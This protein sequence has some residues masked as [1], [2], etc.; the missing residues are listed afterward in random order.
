MLLGCHAS[1]SSEVQDAG[2]KEVQETREDVA[3]FEAS[4]RCSGIAVKAGD[5]RGAVLVTNLSPYYLVKLTGVVTIKKPDGT[6]SGISGLYVSEV[7]APPGEA[8]PALFEEFR[9]SE[10]AD[11]ALMSCFFVKQ[12]EDVRTRVE[13]NRAIE[14]KRDKEAVEASKAKWKAFGEETR[15]IMGRIRG[16]AGTEP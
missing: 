2:V 14:R 15:R 12:G 3:I 1:V 11:V 16:D 4:R 9:D 6:V 8:K 13:R 5:G 10:I 7:G